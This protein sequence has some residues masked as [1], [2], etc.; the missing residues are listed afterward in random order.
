MISCSKEETIQEEQTEY[1]NS[2]ATIRNN[3]DGETISIIKHVDNKGKISV[4]DVCKIEYQ[5]TSPVIGLDCGVSSTIFAFRL[6]SKEYIS[7]HDFE[8]AECVTLN[9]SGDNSENNPVKVE[10]NKYDSGKIYLKSINQK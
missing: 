7:V 2:Y 8:T 10:L 6:S 3:I 1:I 9:F 5:E 4:I